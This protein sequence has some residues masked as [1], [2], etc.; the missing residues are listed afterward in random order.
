MRRWCIQAVDKNAVGCR[1]SFG[2]HLCESISI[3]VLL[4]WDVVELQT[5]E[6]PFQ[7]ADLLAI[8][9]HERALAVG[10]LQDLDD[11]QLGVAIDVQAGCPDV[12]GYADAA[13]DRLI[14]CNVVGC[15][16][17]EADRV[18]EPASFW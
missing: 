10:V 16:K 12:D 1:L 3:R 2:G 5:P 8:C 4:P 13:D 11:F 6:S 18:L 7:L 15:G 17:M 14:F 9:I